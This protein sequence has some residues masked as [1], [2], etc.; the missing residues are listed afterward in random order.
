MAELDKVHEGVILDGRGYQ[1]DMPEVRGLFGRLVHR[2]S[3]DRNRLI[4]FNSGDYYVASKE[5]EEGET[6]ISTRNVYYTDD[7]EDDDIYDRVEK[8]SLFSGF[9]AESDVFLK[10]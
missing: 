1:P 4:H 6:E 3:T 2:G 7:I 8:K 10:D 5:L 9:F